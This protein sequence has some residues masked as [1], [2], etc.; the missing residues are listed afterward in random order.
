[1]KQ[2][3]ENEKLIIRFLLGDLSGEEREKVE[4]HFFDDDA[5][6]EEM[7]IVE[8]EL[9]DNYLRG[10]LTRENRKKFEDGFLSSPARRKRVDVARTVVNTL[11]DIPDP[12]LPDI[13]DPDPPVTHESRSWFQSLFAGRNR[14]VQF[15]FA[16]VAL[17][18]AAAV[19]WLWTELA[20]ERNALDRLQAE[21]ARLEQRKKEDDEQFAKEQEHNKELTAQLESEQEKIQML[22]Q[23]L[24]RLQPQP[25]PTFELTSGLTRSGGTIKSITIPSGAKTIQL[26]LYIDQSAD[27]IYNAIIET[28]QRE[29]VWSKERLKAQTTSSGKVVSV[30]VPA[31]LFSNQ[32]YVLTLTVVEGNDYDIAGSYVFKVAK[33]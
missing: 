17:L 9:I 2:R 16:S 11:P 4:D 10:K 33:R 18:L 8:E 32:T 27:K 13:P 29:K 3:S 21:R 22:E 26:K 23:Q 7:T 1:M 24:A 19:V 5:F 20:K 31:K 12:D 30:S 28:E 6:F 25:V 14:A 15:A